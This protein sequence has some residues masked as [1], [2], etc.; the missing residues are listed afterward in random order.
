MN[1]NNTPS[2]AHDAEVHAYWV[3]PGRLLA[4][5]YPG[6]K[7]PEKT[8]RKLK[9]LRDAG[10]NSFVDLTEAGETTW[11]GVPMRPY[12]GQLDAGADYRRFAIPDTGVIDDGGYDRILAHIRAELEAGKVVLAHCWG[13]KGRTGTVIGSWLIE[14]LG[15]GYPE[16]IEHMQDLR[17]GTCKA[18]HP[19][20]DTLEQHDVLRRRAQRKEA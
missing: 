20:P 10:I 11:G 1:N 8:A 14:Q 5:E 6:A 12:D 9:V 3:I 13:G 7:T 16:V 17:G 15:L 18:H 19:V 2:W 4:G